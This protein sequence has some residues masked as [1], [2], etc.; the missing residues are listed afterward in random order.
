[1]PCGT[2]PRSSN[3]PFDDVDCPFS[4]P[5]I[6]NVRTAAACW[7]LSSAI[8]ATYVFCTEL[9]KSG[10]LESFGGRDA[11]GG[12]SA[13]GVGP[14]PP[15]KIPAKPRL[16]QRLPGARSIFDWVEMAEPESFGTLFALVRLYPQE[17]C[18]SLKIAV[19]TQNII[20]S[21]PLQCA[22]SRPKFYGRN[23]EWR[24]TWHARQTGSQQFR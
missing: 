23:Y 9:S 8:S 4:L 13:R 1:M 5:R 12:L 20:Q 7:K 16:F 2:A 11:P 22:P 15:Q 3:L 24:R 18:N 10:A 21:Y 6:R 14:E 17:L 19:Q